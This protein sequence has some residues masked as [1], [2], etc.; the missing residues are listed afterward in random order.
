MKRF[1]RSAAESAAGGAPPA[2]GQPIPGDTQP[3]A[4]P[5]PAAAAVQGSAA[6]EGDASELVRLKRERDDAHKR[7]RELETRQAELEDENRRLKTVPTPP[8]AQPDKKKSWL[9]GATFFDDD[10]D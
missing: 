9:Q 8:P 4:T 10:A 5:P 1:L 3:A 2:P 7:Q 6:T